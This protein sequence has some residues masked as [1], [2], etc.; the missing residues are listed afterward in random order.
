M[1]FTYHSYLMRT[2]GYWLT[3]CTLLYPA[4][5]IQHHAVL[6][7]QFTARALVTRIILIDLC[8]I[9]DACCILSGGAVINVPAPDQ[10]EMLC[11]AMAAAA[12]GEI[13]DSDL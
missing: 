8:C 11:D 10:A 6:I 4:R 7:V 1:G 9:G 5:T 3:Y 12:I 2:S 13:D